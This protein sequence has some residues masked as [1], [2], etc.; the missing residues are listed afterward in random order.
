MGKWM[1]QALRRLAD[2][3]DG[4]SLVWAVEYVKEHP[5][6]TATGI[7][8]VLGRSMAS[9]E[10][11]YRIPYRSSKNA[12]LPSDEQMRILPPDLYAKYKGWKHLGIS[13]ADALKI[14][15]D[16]ID[17]NG[18]QNEVGMDEQEAI[19]RLA[20]AVFEFAK[21]TGYVIQVFKVKDEKPIKGPSWRQIK[22][23]V[24]RHTGFDEADLKL[25]GLYE[26]LSTGD[27]A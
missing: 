14:L 8:E 16:R 6:L 24:A 27:N 18:S 11:K 7:R 15:F 25:S 19:N 3:I 17:G 10:E 4:L 9:E 2:K 23:T 21:K 1:A 20:H 22:I 12:G 26:E 5:D 13:K